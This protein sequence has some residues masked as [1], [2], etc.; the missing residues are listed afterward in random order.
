MPVISLRCQIVGVVDG[1]FTT[2]LEGADDIT[3]ARGENQHVVLEALYREALTRR[4]TCPDNHIG[5][6]EL[7]RRHA[8]QLDGHRYL[9][10]VRTEPRLPTILGQPARLT[11]T[12][13]ELQ[14][15]CVRLRG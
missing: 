15:G 14:T 9:A 10:T 1:H 11:H 8:A 5:A 7:L 6:Q 12:R 13:N 4:G 3:A 2:H